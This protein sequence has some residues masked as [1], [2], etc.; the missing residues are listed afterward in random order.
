ME[1]ELTPELTGEIVFAMEDQ[2]GHFLFDSVESR[3]VSMRDKKSAGKADPDDDRYYAIP[4]WDSVSGF[5]MMDHFVAQ[6]RNPVVCEELRSALG[7]G[8]GVFR[9]FKDILKAHPEVERLWHLFKDREMKNLV[10]EWYNSLRD[11]WGLERIGA[12][13]DETEDIVSHDFLFREYENEDEIAY[14]TL[15]D[16]VER[17]VDESLSP[18][19]SDAMDELRARISDGFDSEGQYAVVALTPDGELVGVAVSKPIP[20]DSF[21]SVQLD[22]IAVYPEF[23]GLGIG[24]ELLSRTI[25][26]WSGKGYRWLLFTNPVIPQSFQHVL[27]RSGFVE[28]GHISVLDLADAHYH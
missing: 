9:K 16:S 23:R 15:I 4:M 6:L 7:S 8:H 19:L 10:L 21:L 18:G 13:P 26:R 1:F 3:C 25:A 2:T 17:E 22:T 24:K 20:V 14:E 12:E 27:H 11:F 28:K 5:R